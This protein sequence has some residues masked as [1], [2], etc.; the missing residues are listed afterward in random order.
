M[1][2]LLADMLVEA[3]RGHSVAWPHRDAALEDVN[4][5]LLPGRIS[6]VALGDDD[7]VLGWVGGQP[8]YDGHVWEVHPLVVHPEHQRKGIGR[9]L[10][11]DLEKLVADR[12]GLTLWVGADDEDDRTT[13]GG[14]DPFPDLL[15]A[16]RKMEN[17]GG[18]PFEF[19]LRCGFVLAGICPDANGLGKPDLYL[20]KRIEHEDDE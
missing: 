19:Y 11:E 8:Q 1:H 18:H 20:A 6:R 4:D 14:A 16:L 10:L 12:G 17:V 13:L 5:S 3:F 9:A 2:R 7:A 15:E